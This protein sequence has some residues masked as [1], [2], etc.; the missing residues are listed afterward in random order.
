MN[1]ESGQPAMNDGQPNEDAWA[2]FVAGESDPRESQS[3]A[4]WV[5]ANPADALL[6]QSVKRHADRAAS[7]ASVSVDVEAA[8]AT[9]R[10]KLDASSARDVSS[11][12]VSSRDNLQVLRGGVSRMSPTA[13]A[14]VPRPRFGLSRG[15]A[16]FAAAAAVVSWIG[17]R[18]MSKPQGLSDGARIVATRIGQRDSVVLSD[19]SRVVLAPGSRLTAAAGF[20]N[21]DRT[22]TLD[23]AA[24]FDV[25]HDDAHPFT[26]I[27]AGAE[28]RDVG[29]AFTVKTDATGGV[30]VAVTHG[31]VTVRRENAPTPERVELRAGDRGVVTKGIVSVA[32]GSVT[33]D[34]TTWTRGR[35]AYRDTPLSEVQADLRRWFGVRVIVADSALAR[36]TVTM[37]AQSDS[38]TVINTIV[39]ML[40][41]EMTQRGDSIILRTA[42][43][44][45]N[46]P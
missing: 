43:G 16:A 27:A 34:E 40:G 17:V 42:R 30:S 5:A 33:D 11:R 20:A 37:P 46:T 1:E 10:A 25:K 29:T 45:T 4:T 36:L 7:S 12:D 15:R 19:G 31:I 23:G 26:V 2:R 38:A 22:V 32:R 35:L 8:L 14:S 28:I 3:I 44:G 13:A 18:S 9:V 39:S 24:Y 6:A 41:A 21:G